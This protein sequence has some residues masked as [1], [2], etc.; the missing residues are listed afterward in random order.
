MK[1]VA[2]CLSGQSRTWKYC[3][4]SI[5]SFISDKEYE[6]D[7]FIH[8]WDINT[9]RPLESIDGSEK[10]FYKSEID[11]KSYID[12]YNPKLYKIQSFESFQNKLKKIKN[13]IPIHHN[14]NGNMINQMYS[15]KQS[16]V[17]KRL[18]ERKNG[19]KYDYVIKLRPDLFFAYPSLRKNI[20]LL[21]KNNKTFYAYHQYESNWKSTY[22]YN[23]YPPDM[24]WLFL[25]SEESDIFSSYFG[26]RIKFMRKNIEEYHLY[27]FTHDIG[28][29]P[30]FSKKIQRSFIIN[31]IKADLGLLSFKEINF[32]YI[33]RPYHAVFQKDEMQSI[34]HNK[35]ESIHDE[36]VRKFTHK[37]YILYGLGQPARKPIDANYSKTKM[38]ID[39]LKEN[40]KITELENIDIITL[41]NDDSY[42]K[43][44]IEEEI[45]KYL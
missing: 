15:F 45:G 20:E 2:V 19:F 30:Y 39:I 12:Y 5:K 31:S 33:I 36:L 41:I 16:I 29:D 9:Y 14:D 40:N 18:W 11:T 6:I 10:Y 25:S 4:D 35:N 3:A 28:F 17:L 22:L 1:R 42:I 13:P 37:F 21:E 44:I 23:S 27:R 8:T 32:L 26:K 24:Y 34:I 38:L 43:K 7:Y